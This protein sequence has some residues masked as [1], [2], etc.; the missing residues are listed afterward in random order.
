MS[1]KDKTGDRLVASIRRT[2]AGTEKAADEPVAATPP[3]AKKS[4][5]KRAGAASDRYQ[6]GGR[7]WPD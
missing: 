4:A 2:K 1:T 7:V 5:T 6:V 3:P